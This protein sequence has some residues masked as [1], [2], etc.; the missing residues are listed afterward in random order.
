LKA[1]EGRL[2]L[3][4]DAKSASADRCTDVRMIHR[5]VVGHDE[6]AL[7]VTNAKPVQFVRD[8][9]CMFVTENR[10]ATGNVNIAY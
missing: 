5:K 9:H 8:R 7:H 6:V 10:I 3:S 2:A 4:S 1:F